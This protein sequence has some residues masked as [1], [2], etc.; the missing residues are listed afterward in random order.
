MEFLQAIKET[1][2]KLF[3]LDEV[4]KPSLFIYLNLFLGFGTSP[5]S[6]YSYAPIGEKA[7][8]FYPKVAKNITCCA[9]ISEEKVELLRFF[10]GGGTKN[11]VF[12][13]YFLELIEHL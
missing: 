7:M 10:Y 13:E 8:K 9:T 12:E 5:F 2:T 3:V 4:G 6:N 1:N 11:E